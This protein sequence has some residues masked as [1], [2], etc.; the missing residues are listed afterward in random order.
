MLPSIFAVYRHETESFQLIQLDY[1]NNEIVRFKNWSRPDAIAI[2]KNA[3]YKCWAK[4]QEWYVVPT[5][6]LGAL[7]P[8]QCHT[9]HMSGR[10]YEWWSLRHCLVWS[11]YEIHQNRY[12]STQDAW[13]RSPRIPVLEFSSKL[14][15]PRTVL[16]VYPRW[17]DSTVA[18][19]KYESDR[20]RNEHRHRLLMRYLPNTHTGTFKEEHIDPKDLRIRTP[21]LS[22]EDEILTPVSVERCPKP[23]VKR[24]PFMEDYTCSQTIES[25]L[26]YND[27]TVY[28]AAQSLVCLMTV[29][30]VFSVIAI[31]V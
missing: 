21:K 8:P 31:V 17:C 3:Y 14:I 18:K 30:F 11:N 4:G 9:F 13:M 7:E 19:V 27:E 10:E 16:D 28:N 22:E 23:K 20:G 25:I 24:P 1:E 6:N 26:L 2:Q 15:Y 5:Y 29:F 12:G